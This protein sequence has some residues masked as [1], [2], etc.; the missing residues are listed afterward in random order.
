MFRDIR[1]PI[2]CP[3]DIQLQPTDTFFRVFYGEDTTPTERCFYNPEE[4]VVI[5][6]D[7][8]EETFFSSSFNKKGQFMGGSD[9]KDMNNVPMDIRE[10]LLT[11]N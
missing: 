9:I 6:Y 11:S 8:R 7:I 1:V 2:S 3:E 10:A 4:G 5:G